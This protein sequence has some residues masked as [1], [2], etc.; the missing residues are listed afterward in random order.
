[1]PTFQ[2]RERER[3]GPE[4]PAS[5]ANLHLIC[6]FRR[7]RHLFAL[8]EKRKRGKPNEEKEKKNRKSSLRG[9]HLRGA[10]RIGRDRGKKVAPACPHDP[11]QGRKGKKTKGWRPF[12]SGR[13]ERKK[14][15]KADPE[16][17]AV[18]LIFPRGEKEDFSYLGSLGC[19]ITGEHY[20][21]G[22]ACRIWCRG[23]EKR[24]RKK[25][26]RKEERNKE[27]AF[28]TISKRMSASSTLRGKKRGEDSPPYGSSKGSGKKKERKRRCKTQTEELLHRKNAQALLIDRNRGKGTLL[29]EPVRV[30]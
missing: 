24:P 25:K 26:G 13:R 9:G 17:P 30:A 2:S 23:K 18:F 14:G 4:L 19:E 10:R 7:K 12:G 16:H 11:A 6:P 15:E 29:A 21:L 3:T 22:E 1:V 20:T 5:P 28:T 8:D 27:A